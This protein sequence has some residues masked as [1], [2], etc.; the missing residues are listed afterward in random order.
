M[1]VWLVKAETLVASV[2][3]ALVVIL[4]F[5][6]GLMRWFGLPL[7]WSVDMAQ[8]LFIWVIFLGAD[9]A[10][11]KRAHI[12]IDLLVR[13]LSGRARVLLDVL[14]AALAI[15]FLGAMALL[16]YRLTMLNIERQFGDS[17]ISYAFVTVAVPAGSALLALTLAGQVRRAIQSLGG[18]PQ[19][20]FAA[21]NGADAE[22][23]AL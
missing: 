6:A 12:G 11:R 18:R 4:V 19:P 8:L 17:G 20:I 5:V 21:E 10:L 16:G 1:S 2:L 14:L 9:L 7:I 22:K 3:L 13:R 23:T 15:A